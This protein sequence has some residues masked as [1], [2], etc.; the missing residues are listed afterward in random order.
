MMAPKEGEAE[1]P[2]ARWAGE[3]MEDFGRPVIDMQ[4]REIFAP[5]DLVI[6]GAPRRSAPQVYSPVSDSPSLLPP[7][8]GLA[9]TTSGMCSL[10]MARYYT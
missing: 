7:Q 10:P 8:E 4:P 3:A 9:P 2:G 6:W 5:Y 1:L